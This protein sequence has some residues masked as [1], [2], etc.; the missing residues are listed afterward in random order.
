MSTLFDSVSDRDLRARIELTNWNALRYFN[1][2]RL[3]IAGVVTVLS[4]TG[5]MPPNL[6][7][8]DVR[9]LSTTALIYLGSAAFAQW[10]IEE[11][12]FPYRLQ[13]YGLSLLDII[14]ITVMMHAAGGVTSGFGVLLVVAVAG[15]CLLASGRAGV[16]FAALATLAFLGETVFGSLYLAYPSANYTQAGLLG[17]ACFGTAILATMLAERARRSEALAAQRAVDIENLSL[18]NEH[19]VRRMRAGVMALNPR[20]EN[21]IDERGGGGNTG[22]GDRADDAATAGF[23]QG[24]G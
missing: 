2:Y 23:L 22:A 24:S 9:L 11:K 8:L 21:C 17:A 13:V 1:L 14:A 20:A 15:T 18:L 10:S 4:T 3:V 5:K 7:T 6:S 16:F 12:T 19:I